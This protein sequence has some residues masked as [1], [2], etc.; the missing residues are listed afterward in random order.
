MRVIRDQLEFKTKNTKNLLFDSGQKL[1]YK[2]PGILDKDKSLSY[3]CLNLKDKKIRSVIFI[4]RY[5]AYFP[6]VRE[7]VSTV[8]SLR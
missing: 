6:C 5:L 8:T 4:R 1:N 2:K 7:L 3:S